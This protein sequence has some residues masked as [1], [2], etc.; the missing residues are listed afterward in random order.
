MT[1]R[2]VPR[3]HGEGL[4]A[5]RCIYSKDALWALLIKFNNIL[6]VRPQ[7]N[8]SLIF[9]ARDNCAFPNASGW[10][11]SFHIRSCKYSHFLLCF[12]CQ[13][14]MATHL[15]MYRTL[16]CRCP[17]RQRFAKKYFPPERM[18]QEI[19]WPPA[20]STSCSWGKSWQLSRGWR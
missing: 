7:R 15:E 16:H 13:K 8:D 17:L 6:F 20:V 10:P 5:V 4:S 2:N 1:S 14:C 9:N 11:S 12:G 19:P 3:C 18:L